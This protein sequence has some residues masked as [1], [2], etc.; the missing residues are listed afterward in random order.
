MLL[1]ES[2]DP[3]C[4]CVC[5]VVG[6][7]RMLPLV[8]GLFIVSGPTHKVGSVQLQ[9]QVCCA[10]GDCAHKDDPI[11]DTHFDCGHELNDRAL[12]SLCKCQWLTLF[13]CYCIVQMI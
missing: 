4:L 11:V 10:S 1:Q 6:R 12:Q 8:A 5:W 3:G 13:E 7:R 2:R 9:Q